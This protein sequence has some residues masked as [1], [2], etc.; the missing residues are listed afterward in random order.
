MA[1]VTSRSW[2]RTALIGVV[3]VAL[4]GCG[5]SGNP[6]ATSATATT[7]TGSSWSVAPATPPDPH[8]L[9]RAAASAVAKVP[10]GTLTFIQSQTDDTGTWKVRVVTPDG[11]EQQVK[12]G[13]DGYAVLVGPN[14]RKDSDAD[15]AKRRGLVQTAHLDYQAAMNKMLAALP[16]GSITELELDDKN[17]TTMWEAVVWDTNLVGH[18]VAINAASGELVANNQV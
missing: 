12:V 14:P 15:K 1:A 18:K 16:N 3:L 9:L 10:G 7:T 4:A 11:Y 13:S 17:G 6:S 5:H 2:I 8:T